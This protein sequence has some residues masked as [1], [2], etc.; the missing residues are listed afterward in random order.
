MEIIYEKIF[1]PHKHS[2]ITRK[3]Q[4]APNS[5]KIHSHKNFELNYIISGSGKRIIGNS[6]SSYL[7]EISYFWVPIFPIAGMFWSLGRI[8]LPDVL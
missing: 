2:F 4:M 8:M 1:V 5:H 6:I 7:K 3:M